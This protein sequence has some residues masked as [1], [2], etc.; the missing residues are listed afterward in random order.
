MHK[1]EPYFC[2]ALDRK[3]RRFFFTLSDP[4][5][6]PEEETERHQFCQAKQEE[7]ETTHQFVTRF[8]QLSENCTFGTSKEE[9]IRDQLI[10]KCRSHDLRKKLLAVN[11]K[12]TLEKARDFARSMEAAEIQVRSIESDSRSG[13]VNSSSSETQGL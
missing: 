8:F 10:D 13:T 7:S 6:T 4:G 11:G 9:Q 12:L 5:P 3:F 2:N 1:N